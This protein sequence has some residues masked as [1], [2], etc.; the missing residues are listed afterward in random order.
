MRFE[1]LIWNG[2]NLNQMYSLS[3]SLLP[4]IYSELQSSFVSTGEQANA[5]LKCT[6]TFCCQLSAG[7]SIILAWN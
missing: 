2:D 3:K 4:D 7:H 1:M 6:F 5:N